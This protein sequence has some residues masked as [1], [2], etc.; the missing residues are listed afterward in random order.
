MAFP[1]TRLSL[2]IANL[3]T[4]TVNPVMGSKVDKF[5]GI[6]RAIRA[7]HYCF[8]QKWGGRPIFFKR[9]AERVS[10]DWVVRIVIR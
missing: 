6:I 4:L 2:L 10:G 1:F 7:T 3:K 8:E 9:R 5:D